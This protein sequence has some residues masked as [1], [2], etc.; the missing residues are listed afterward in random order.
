VVVDRTPNLPIGRRTLP[1]T[2][3]LMPPYYIS[4]LGWYR[5]GLEPA[6]LSEIVVDREVFRVLGMLSPRLP[7]K[8]K[9]ARK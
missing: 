8:E 2:T 3:D 5:L 4:D 7:P 9:R 1:Y 6:K